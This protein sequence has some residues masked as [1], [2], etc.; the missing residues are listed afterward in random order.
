MKINNEKC[1]GCRKC[2]AYCPAEA[3]TA[4]GKSAC[5]DENLCVECSVCIRSGICANAA[6][7]QLPLDWPRVLRAQFSDPFMFHPKTK[8][9]GRG[10]TEIKTNDVSNRYPAGIVGFAIEVG[11][12]GGTAN[13]TDVEKITMAVAACADFEPLNPLTSLIDTKSGKLTDPSIQNERFISAIIECKTDENNGL[14]VL[15]CL[16]AVAETIDTV[17]SVSVINKCVNG[18]IPFKKTMKEAGFIPAVN[19]KTNVGLGRPLA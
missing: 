9:K 19:G 17:F 18:E 4:E 5:I 1:N 15:K 11:R 3:I 8:I 7:F 2:L 13:F 12:P 10:T 6:F 14:R 16:E